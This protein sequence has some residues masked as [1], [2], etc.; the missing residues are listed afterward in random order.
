[1]IAVE[2]LASRGPSIE[3]AVA[4]ARLR[5]RVRVD[6]AVLERLARAR[7]TLDRVASVQAIY[8]LNTGLGAKSGT[9]MEGDATAFQTQFL[10]GRAIAMG[11]PLPTEIV[12]AAM[13]AR[14][15]GLA[16][17]GS[18]VSPAVFEALVAAL[19]AGV[20]A[21][22]P[23]L[24]SIGAAD[25]G[26]MAALG[27]M[28]IGEGEAEFEGRI[29]PAKTALA[30]AG[31]RPVELGPKDGLSL[32]SASSVS[33][34]E[35][36]LVVSDASALLGQQNAAVALTMEGLGSNPAI[37]DARLQA[38]RPS[39]GQAEVAA[40]LR[41]L[42][43]GSA[44]AD[45]DAAVPL[46][47]P[48]SVRCAPSING[49]ARHAVGHARDM[50]EL[51]LRSA[52]DNPLVLA[53]AGEVLSTGNFHGPA[54]ALAFETLSLAMAQTAIAC[55]GRFVQLTGAGRNGLPR[56]LSPQGGASAGFVSLQKTA[57]AL[58]A[59]IRRAAQPVILDVM[60]VSEGVEDHATQAPLAVSKCADIIGLWR[61]LVAL[62]LMAAGQAADL[63]GRRLGQ[64]TGRVQ[65]ALR[66]VVEP[67]DA[68]R[69][70]GSDAER[71]TQWLRDEP[72]RFA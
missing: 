2:L 26:L 54:L 64:G 62:E 19:N 58:L 15:A 6:P 59:A 12:R 42:I 61:R 7:S 66:R 67:L 71:L 48:L 38:A 31:L 68:D 60:P 37:L 21:V 40:E 23:R 36:A 4:V 34:G 14:A 50:V 25:L 70:L 53:E 47:D 46:Q 27:R 52:A 55:A 8:G 51:E 44:L 72:S 57:G 11:D 65:A 28:L 30:A 17:G 20:H 29:V 3:E 33:V 49:A 9:A 45:P 22:M 39:P 63:R 35:G 18:G 13:F 1:V 24:G 16:A 41:A 5:A 56:N 43:E 69:P 32:I 10:R